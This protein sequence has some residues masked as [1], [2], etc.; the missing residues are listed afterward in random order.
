[1]SE[2]NASFIFFDWSLKHLFSFFVQ[3]SVFLPLLTSLVSGHQ[4]LIRRAYSHEFRM[5]S[6]A[7]GL[8]RRG[9]L[10]LLVP[11]RYIPLSFI[12]GER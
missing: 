1:M 9:S 5:Q 4:F 10:A 3:G 12:I 7:E 2:R 11:L 6:T 8:G